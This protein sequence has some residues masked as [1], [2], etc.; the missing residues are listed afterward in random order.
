MDNKLLWEIDYVVGNTY[1]K[2]YITA[3]TSQEALDKAKV[4]NIIDLNI[5]KN[6]FKEEQYDALVHILRTGQLEQKDVDLLD[7]SKMP[8]LYQDDNY[9]ADIT[10]EDLL[11]KHQFTIDVYAYLN[12]KT[13][14]E[15]IFTLVTL[16]NINDVPKSYAEFMALL[17]NKFLHLDEEFVKS[18]RGDYDTVEY[19]KDIVDD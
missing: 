2:K 7:C 17:D 18:Y 3:T 4:K 6:N 12:N 14:S 8:L 11:N 1:K 19:D 13:E 10:L 16:D 9:Y 5:S 15:W